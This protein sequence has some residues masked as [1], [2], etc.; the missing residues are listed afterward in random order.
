ATVI[1]MQN[2]LITRPVAFRE[3]MKSNS[4]EQSRRVF[5]KELVLS[6]SALMLAGATGPL[7]AQSSPDWKNQIGLELF[8]VRDLLRQDYE[9][10]LAKLSKIGYKHVEPADPYNNME[11]KAYKELL[12]KYGLKMYSTHS[13]AS[14]GPD[15][16]KELEGQALMGI[17]YTEVRS[18]RR[19]GRPPS[20]G[21][22]G[23]APAA[24]GPPGPGGPPTAGAVGPGGAPGQGGPPRSGPFGPREPRTV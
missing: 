8:T 13:G 2:N 11:P 22:P 10:V 15:L 1:H 14:D 21:P 12:E 6:S 17:K 3:N 18:G 19:P 5:I 4:C 16:E 9:G 24:G 20:G 23:G 7:M